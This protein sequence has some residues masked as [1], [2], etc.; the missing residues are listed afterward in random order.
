MS[1]AL[2]GI[3]IADFSRVLSGPLA[4][5]FLADLGAEVI[6][7]E[8]PETGDDTRG[9]GPPFLGED[10]TYYLAAN[11]GKK[12][13]VLDLSSTEGQVA[14]QELVRRSDVLVQNFR[15]GTMDRFG[16]GYAACQRL[17][18]ALV[19]CSISGFGSGAGRDLPSYDFIVQAVGGLM[20]ITG[21]P[22]LQPM[23]AGVALVDVLVGLHAVIGILA[24]VRDASTSGVGTHVELNLLSSLLSSLA[25]QGS[26]FA[27]A[28]VL[29]ERLGNF[30]PSI[31]PYELFQTSDRSIAVACGN[32]RQFE[33]LCGVLGLA[34]LPQDERFRSNRVR[35]KHR[36]LLHSKLAD[37]LAERTS[38]DVVVELSRVGVP[39]GPV[40]NLAEAFALADSL[41]L[42]P[43]QHLDGSGNRSS[44]IS[45]PLRFDGDPLELGSQPP[46]LGEHT[47]EVLSW[48]AHPL[49]GTEA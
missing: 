47:E 8:R 20:S 23:K 18:P 4:T 40:N 44:Q 7:V 35:V 19:Y 28:G 38:G 21:E 10:S 1:R 6:K 16:L 26:A 46:R 48:L 33:E 24:G 34:D 41:G 37:A 11:R 39:V 25:N 43:V 2:E 12:S 45:S 27:L 13:V 9:W 30:H 22:D 17:N 32:D 29:P 14:A 36:E 31:A 3:V 42:Q 5:M 15:P 49:P